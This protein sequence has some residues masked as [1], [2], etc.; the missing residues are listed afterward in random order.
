MELFTLDRRFLRQDTIDTFHSAIW[1]ERYYGDGEAELVVPATTEFIQMLKEGTFL[2]EKDSNEVIII[3]KLEIDKE[4][5]L[6][7]T[8]ESLLKFLNN[9]FI[10]VS[11]L[12]QDRYWAITGGPGWALW[13]IVYYMC[14]EGS[15]YLNGQAPTGIPNP[16][17]LAIPNLWLSTYDE[18]LPVVN[19]AVPYAPIF[20]ALYQIATTYQLGMS[21]YLESATEERYQLRFRNYRG[22]NRTSAQ[23]VN[24]QV[25]FSPSMDSLTDVE[26]LRSIESFKTQVHSFAPSNPDDLATTAGLAQYI[27][28]VSYTG[29]D[30][31]AMQVFAEDITTDTINGDAN[32]LLS[33][34]N[35]RAHDALTKNS[36]VKV[37]DGEIVPTAQFKYGRDYNLGDIV[38]LQGNS[39]IVQNARVT[40]YIRTQDDTGERA[41]PT[42]A[43]LD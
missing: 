29:F 39:G 8:G 37:V 22:L 5:K 17:A 18:S 10:R 3:E 43:I 12:H 14:V 11:P 20:D 38:E 40:E 32:L 33:I 15:P 21:L 27:S 16:Q 13:A 7:V 1:T 19:I 41:Y 25:R 9:R 4:G 31:R 28:G 26:E 2:R 6:K 23:T 42:V 34:L 24:A 35:Q 36:F 30:L